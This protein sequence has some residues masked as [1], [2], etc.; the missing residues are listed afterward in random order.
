M[1][2]TCLVC[3]GY[4]Q[5]FTS[6]VVVGRPRIPRRSTPP[7]VGGWDMAVRLLAKSPVALCTGAA[8]PRFPSTPLARRAKDDPDTELWDRE[9]F[10][11]RTLAFIVLIYALV[12]AGYVVYKIMSWL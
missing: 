7:A 2:S 6:P 12:T 4:H 8:R 10:K 9:T 3:P 11:I 5:G 1:Q